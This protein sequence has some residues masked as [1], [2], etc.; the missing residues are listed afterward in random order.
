M[1]SYKK[2]EKSLYTLLIK[3]YVI[4]AAVLLL[5]VQILGLLEELM[6][7]KIARLPRI[8]HPVG[9]QEK[10][11]DED[12]GSLSMKALLG[13]EGYFDIYTAA[14]ER[15]YT[16]Y[17]AFGSSYTPEEISLIPECNTHVSY[18][19]KNYEM[20]D[21]SRQILVTE[22]KREED[23]GYQENIAYYLFDG[24]LR[25]LESSVSFPYKQITER[26]LRLF[27]AA[28]DNGYSTYKYSYRTGN[29]EDRI[30][31]MHV[32]R[33][34]RQRVKRLMV[35]KQIFIPVY[36]LILIGATLFFALW[37][38]RRVREPLFILKNGIQDFADGKRDTVLSYQG[39]REFEDIFSSFNRMA[40]QLKESESAKEHLIME[41]QRM[42]ADI[43]HDL[44]HRSR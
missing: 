40:V 10:L 19:T 25:L 23:T 3:N 16:D 30:L 31:L 34:D 22:S 18:E 44:K 36:V 26:E 11:A 27:T 20:E 39:P 24:E 14:G 5:A 2:K 28:T 6:D 35:F 29:G 21:G 7:Q 9:E 43:S 15:L 32:K 13:T 12:Y 37:M 33:M 8:D 1:K 4:F 41:K 42:L 17:D 38:H